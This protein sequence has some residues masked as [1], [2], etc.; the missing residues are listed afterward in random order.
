MD[1]TSTTYITGCW[2]DL[3]EAT[4]ALCMIEGEGMITERESSLLDKI[5]GALESHDENWLD[6]IIPDIDDSDDC[7]DDGFFDP[8]DN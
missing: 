4:L 6:N 8:E 7:F 5:V 1:D 2:E 3:M